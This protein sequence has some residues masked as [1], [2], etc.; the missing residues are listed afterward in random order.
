M[1]H[2][3]RPINRH[4]AGTDF[5]T[6]R[7]SAFFGRASAAYR[8]QNRR[9][10]GVRILAHAT[11][12]QGS[13]VLWTREESVDDRGSFRRDEDTVAAVVDGDDLFLGAPSARPS[14]R[15]IE[16]RA[17]VNVSPAGVLRWR[18]RLN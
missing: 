6:T 7:R 9:R 2:A 16:S 10:H 1:E 14:R 13:G 4:S 3:R 12:L 15:V 8:K 5:A 18:L 17:I 11:P